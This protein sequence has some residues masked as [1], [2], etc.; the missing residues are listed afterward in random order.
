MNDEIRPRKVL[1]ETPFVVGT[2]DKT[3]RRSSSSTNIFLEKNKP[4]NNTREPLK[5][6][7]SLQTSNDLWDNKTKKKQRQHSNSFGSQN[8]PIQR[9][10]GRPKRDVRLILLLFNVILLLFNV[11]LLLFNSNRIIFLLYRVVK[12]LN[13]FYL[14]D[15]LMLY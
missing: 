15:H 8:N 4:N 10:P 12:L 14:M 3:N 13:Q 5:S 9:R 6:Q 2:R 7:L 11:I 1:V